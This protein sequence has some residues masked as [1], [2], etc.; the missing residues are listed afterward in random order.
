MVNV[1][2]TSDQY[3]KKDRTK[4]EN[5]NSHDRPNQNSSEAPNIKLKIQITQV[6]S[7]VMG[8]AIV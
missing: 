8:R 5:R 1:F 6:R 3:N 7:N 4:G 2:E